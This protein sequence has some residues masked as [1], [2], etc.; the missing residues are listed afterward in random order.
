MTSVLMNTMD[1]I[2]YILEFLCM[3]DVCNF[4]QTCKKYLENDNKF[5]GIWKNEFMI[6]TLT[7]SETDISCSNLVGFSLTPTIDKCY[8][9]FGIAEDDVCYHKIQETIS[10]PDVVFNTCIL[11]D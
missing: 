7:S 10:I 6:G 1:L 3:N 5:R 2:K 4:R 8:S 11:K 9:P